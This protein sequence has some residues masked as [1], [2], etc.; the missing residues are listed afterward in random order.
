MDKVILEL[1]RIT[2]QVGLADSPAEQVRLIV[3]SICA[4]I[5]V[6]VCSLYRANADGDMLL[7]AS[8][9]LA[10]DEKVVIPAGHGLVGLVATGRHPVNLAEA[11]DHEDYFYIPQT[12]EER[13]ASFCGVPLVQQGEVLGVL[14]VQRAEPRKLEPEAKAFL[15]TLAA[16]LAFIVANIPAQEQCALFSDRQSTGIRG[17]PGIAIG[18]AYMLSGGELQGVQDR[19]CDSIELELHNWHRL[20]EITREDVRLER[21]ALGGELADSVAAIFDAYD[22][23]L[24]DQSLIK[25]V[26]QEIRSGHWLPWALRVSIQYFAELFRAMDDP[27][28]RARHED[29]QH[30]GSKLYE[31][32]RG[33]H[34]TGK[35]RQLP[36]GP[37]VL[38]GKQVSVS[39]IAA[40]PPEQLAGIVCLEGSSMSHVAVVA[41]AMGVPAVMGVDSLPRL[42]DGELLVVDGNVGQVFSNPGSALLREFRLLIDQEESLRHQLD[43]L[44]SQPAVTVDGTRVRLMT[45]TG[46]L[47]DITPGLKSGAEGVGLYRTEIPF[48]VRDSF[49]TED[50]QVQVYRTVLS[51]YEGKPVH[52]RTL[53]IGG[54]KQLSYFPIRA[55]ENPAL[56][57]RGIRFTLDNVQLLMSQVR[58]MVRAAEG[59]D[60]LRILV[61]MVSS[62]HEIDRFIQLLDDACTQL[63]KE[64]YPVL[65]PQVG[66]M[67]E[68]PAAIPQ[69][70]FWCRK[71][72]F[73]S[74]GSND[75]SQY[76]LALD[77]NNPR[78]GKRF[79]HVHPAVLHEIARVVS[80][81]R[82]CNVPVSLCGEMASDPAAVVLLVGMGIRSLS[83]SAALLP[84]VKWLIRSISLPE[85]ESILQQALA[86]DDVAD[87]RKLVNAMLSANELTALVS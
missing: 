46:L 74:I 64:G 83:M 48:M 17:A 67:L 27:Y 28:L 44:R 81:A 4:A 72:D 78:V 2:Q 85:A 16:Q 37:L 55:E 18:S 51:A 9:G 86:C 57:W 54:D 73:I 15:M 26:E 80:I 29:I 35:I 84:R 82:E 53:D 87:I 50:E 43:R 40:I 31:V 13:Y 68:V 71:I 75:L 61:P 7:L 79:D 52:M 42:Q 5:Q 47:A 32:W 33:G 60:N 12:R 76:L 62:T 65:R 25:Q 58:S 39:D 21:N 23:L 38:V 24:A 77:R 6:E 45:N 14:V 34:L 56:G 1:T 36:D 63:L 3:D 49:P 69:L 30:L 20:L 8:H 22:M 41:N 59:I 11:A 19:R 66:V 70:R 10:S